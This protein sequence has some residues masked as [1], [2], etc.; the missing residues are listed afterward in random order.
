MAQAGPWFTVPAGTPASECSGCK[1]TIY[2]ID[3]EARCDV[4]INCDVPGGLRPVRFA[5]GGAAAKD[6]GRGRE[7]SPECPNLDRVRKVFR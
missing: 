5:A 1:A 3:T 6:H 2:R 4:L 7:H